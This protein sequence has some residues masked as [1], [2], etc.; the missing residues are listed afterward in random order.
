MRHAHLLL[1]AV[2][3]PA[4]LRDKPDHSNT[5][6][7]YTSDSDSSAKEDGPAGTNR[8]SELEA[9]RLIPAMRNQLDLIASGSRV[10]TENMTA[11]RNLAGDLINS[12]QADL[13]RVGLADSGDFRALGDSVM[14][15]LGGGRAGDVATGPHRSQINQHVARMRRLID[16]YQQAMRN[17]GDK[18]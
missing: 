15:D 5:A 18:L 16:L 1:L 4:C 14:D 11:Y 10:S 13:T 9:P 8:G 17:A 12:M 7:A 2:L 3:F 6:S